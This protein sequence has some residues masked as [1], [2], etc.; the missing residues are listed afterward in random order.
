MLIVEGP[1][2]SGK[3]TL[4]KALS[5][6]TSL[7]VAQS[8]SSSR[9]SMPQQGV[10]RRVF[11]AISAL[12]RGEILI[13]DRLYFSELVYGS[14]LR[15]AALFSPEEQQWINGTLKTYNVP[16]IV[17]LPPFQTVQ[18]N[19]MSGPSDSHIQGVRNH[20]EEIWAQYW[21][22]TGEVT[23]VPMRQYDYTRETDK[24]DDLI[25]WLKPFTYNFERTF[26]DAHST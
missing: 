6:G 23:G 21:D 2:G 22:L 5:E 18:D 11:S 16:V 24:V 14:I 9:H 8:F 17:C 12:L 10:R 4:V 26:R 25:E 20:I 3:S 7:E 13:H 15:G 1:D 19:V